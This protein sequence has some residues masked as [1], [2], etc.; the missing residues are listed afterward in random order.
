MVFPDSRWRAQPE[1]LS[2]RP[3]VREVPAREGLVD[4]HNSGMILIILRRKLAATEDLST[5]GAEVIPAY[6]I[7]IG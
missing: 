3:L 7:E 4:D 5:H 6:W 1:P 2:E